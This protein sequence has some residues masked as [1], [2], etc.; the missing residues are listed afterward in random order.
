MGFNRNFA[1]DKFFFVVRR[2]DK[3]QRRP[4]RTFVEMAEE[5]GL[6]CGQLAAH[7]GHSSHPVPKARV[8]HKGTATTNSK[9]YYNP[10][11][12]RAWW[13][14]HNSTIKKP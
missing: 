5:F 12:V 14:L 8:T 13:K 7:F 3:E 11:E 6:T 10:E 1:D 2:C 9:S 4:L